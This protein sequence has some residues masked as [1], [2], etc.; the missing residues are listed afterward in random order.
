MTVTFLELKTGESPLAAK[1]LSRSTSSSYYLYDSTTSALK[2][3]GDVRA[4]LREIM[5]RSNEESGV[6]F[7]LLNTHLWFVHTGSSYS[8]TGATG[9]ENESGDSDDDEDRTTRQMVSVSSLNLVLALSRW[10]VSNSV[11]NNLFVLFEHQVPKYALFPGVTYLADFLRPASTQALAKEFS[12]PIGDRIVT[13]PN[14]QVVG[15]FGPCGS[16]KTKT[17]F[18]LP[19]VWMRVHEIVHC[20]LG[21]SPRLVREFFLRASGKRPS[22]LVLDDAD[23]VLSTS[24]RIMREIVEEIGTCLG[25][26]PQVALVFSARSKNGCGLPSIILSR[27]SVVIELG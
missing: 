11:R 22:I 4:I 9:D 27:C 18:S 26:F 20:E 8:Y 6:N 24:G 12:F 16:G 25:D 17:L 5:N 1:E 14:D 3:R 10:F 2:H 15:I 13:F 7:V 23:L 19:A 21:E